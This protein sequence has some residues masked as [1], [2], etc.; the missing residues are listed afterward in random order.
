MADM[1]YQAAL[2]SSEE[3]QKL[4]Q[5]EQQFSRETGKNIVLVA[6]QEQAEKP[7]FSASPQS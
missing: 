3:L 4:Q 1:P 6:Y 2:L 5:W 7:A